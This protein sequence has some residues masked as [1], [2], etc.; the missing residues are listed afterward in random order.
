MIRNEEAE[1]IVKLEHNGDLRRFRLSGNPFPTYEQFLVQ[2]SNRVIGESTT[3]LCRTKNP[4][5]R[6]DEGDWVTIA[7]D[8]DVREACMLAKSKK[9]CLRVQLCDRKQPVST[10]S[11]VIGSLFEE[12]ELSPSVIQSITG[13]VYDSEYSTP[14]ISAAPSDA[15]SVS[16]HDISTIDQNIESAETCCIPSPVACEEV[17]KFGKSETCN[18][19]GVDN[20]SL[21]SGEQNDSFCNDTDQRRN[22]EYPH[23]SPECLSYAPGSRREYQIGPDAEANRNPS[24]RGFSK[25]SSDASLLDSLINEGHYHRLIIQTGVEHSL[26][27]FSNSRIRRKLCASSFLVRSAV[28][29]VYEDLRADFAHM[30]PPRVIARSAIFRLKEVGRYTENQWRLIRQRVEEDV[31]CAVA[32]YNGVTEYPDLV[33]PF[34]RNMSR[35]FEGRES[36][37][38]DFNLM[39]SSDVESETDEPHQNGMIFESCDESTTIESTS[40]V[41]SDRES[42]NLSGKSTPTMGE[43]PCDIPKVPSEASIACDTL[44]LSSEGKKEIG[45]IASEDESIHTPES[46]EDDFVLVSS[47]D[48]N[49]D[50]VRYEGSE[51]SN[52]EII[53][54]LMDGKGSV[55]GGQAEL[56]DQNLFREQLD[57][58]DEMGF[59]DTSLNARYLSAFNGNVEMVLDEL[60]SRD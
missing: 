3:V 41:R 32:R 35:T 7:C 47:R 27:R 56:Q 17:K 9:L 40:D 45:H 43:K 59:T 36:S 51:G 31:A 12:R 21:S 53:Y 55:C 25:C 15:E 54:P 16:G 22:R 14:R 33:D 26:N 23:V 29:D 4:K 2:C 19:F 24:G 44:S 18:D 46:F 10:S 48:S 5:Y 42:R 52:P 30:P 1:V 11:S 37:G 57:T 50:E 13:T 6:D 39:L 60:V 28:A 20:S 38:V 58:L 34:N 49:S 8:E